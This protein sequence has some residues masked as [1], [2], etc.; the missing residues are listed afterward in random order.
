MKIKIY[1][2]VIFLLVTHIGSAQPADLFDPSFIKGLIDKNT[3]WFHDEV[4]SQDSANSRL[5]TWNGAT[6]Y[7]GLL[8]AWKYTNDENYLKQLKA[9]GECFDWKL[10]PG[11]QNSTANNLLIGDVYL[12]MSLLNKDT[13]YFQDLKLEIERI[14]K[15]RFTG[16]DSWWWVDALYMGP[17]SFALLSQVT[18]DTEYLEFMHEKWQGTYRELYDEK[19]NLFYRDSNWVYSLGDPQARTSS[20]G[21]IF[22]S[23]GNGWAVAGICR[24]LNYLPE[25]HPYRKFYLRTL[26]NTQKSIVKYQQPDGLWTT[27]I[28][29]QKDFPDTETSGSALFCYTMAWGINNGILSKKKYEPHLRE[30]WAALVRNIDSKGCMGR[31]QIVA[32]QPGNVKETDTDWFGQGQF[33][34]AAVEVLKM[35][36]INR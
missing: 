1:V 17:P 15:G 25:S 7:S 10:F 32:H 23:R 19:A 18:G 27:N 26:R 3:A 24:L 5:I 35:Y 8:E 36:S 21:K 9:V 29:D 4:I 16:G 13:V 20:E 31:C 14:M 11:H 33:L 22:W 6:Y 28:I 12:N 30:A 34:L 2:F